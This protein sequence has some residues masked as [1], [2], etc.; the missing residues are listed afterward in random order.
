MHVLHDAWL[1]RDQ[2]LQ[3]DVFDLLHCFFEVVTHLREG[4]FELLEV[5]LRRIA[6]FFLVRLIL[7][8]NE[9]G[10]IFLIDAKVGQVDVLLID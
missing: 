1:D 3:C 9:F 4:C 6:F 8:G 7:V 2:G 5:P 10:C